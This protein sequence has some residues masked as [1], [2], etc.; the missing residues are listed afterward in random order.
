VKIVESLTLVCEEA[1]FGNTVS[2]RNVN[3]ND[4]PAL[5]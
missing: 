3:N 1:L 2:I 5:S 4:I